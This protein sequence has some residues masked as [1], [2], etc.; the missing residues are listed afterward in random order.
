M[1]K[2]SFVLYWGICIILSNLKGIVGIVLVLK[3]VV[4]IVLYLGE[5]LFLLIVG[6]M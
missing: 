6:F 2:V 4:V 3:W 1:V 5:N